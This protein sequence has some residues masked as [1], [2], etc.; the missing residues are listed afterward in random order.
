M[1]AAVGHVIKALKGE[2]K[3]AS[4]SEPKAKAE[5]AAACWPDDDRVEAMVLLRQIHAKVMSL[6]R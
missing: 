6:R 3:A 4:E 5:D 1:I 2:A